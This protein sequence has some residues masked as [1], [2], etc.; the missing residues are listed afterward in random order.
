MTFKDYKKRPTGK[1]TNKT[2]SFN[3]SNACC[4]A[5][6]LIQREIDP[7]FSRFDR[8]NRYNF[9]LVDSLIFQTQ[10]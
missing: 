10:Y 6:T 7:T 5:M 8:W 4:K 1:Q 9:D 2:I 3:E